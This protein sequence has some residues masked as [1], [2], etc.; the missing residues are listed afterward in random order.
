M[1]IQVL[2]SGDDAPRKT[3]TLTQYIKEHDGKIPQKSFVKRIFFPGKVPNYSFV[4]DHDFRVNIH[5]DNALFKVLCEQMSEWADQEVALVLVL[6]QENLGLFSVAL[7]ADQVVNWESKPW[8]YNCN[9]F[10]PRKAKTA[11]GK[12]TRTAD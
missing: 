4:T 11:A 5:R 7:D 1:A 3:P 12:A 10:K 6:D 8:G 2:G 9:D